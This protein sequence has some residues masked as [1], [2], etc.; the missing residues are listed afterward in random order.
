NFFTLCELLRRQKLKITLLSTGL[1]I[2]RHAA[3]LLQW[4]DEIIVSLDGDEKTH[5]AIRNIPGAYQKMKEGIQL[6]HSIKPGYPV[7]GRTVIHRLNFRQWPAL[8]E[9]AMDIGLQRISFLPADV[10]S[11]AFNRPA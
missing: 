4:V 7:S 11:E 3:Q 8:I 5:D 1:L 9:S 6:L 2:K 10:S